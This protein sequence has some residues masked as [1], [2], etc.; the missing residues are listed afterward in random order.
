[1]SSLPI[2]GSLDQDWVGGG[3]PPA[4]ATLQAWEF[5]AE[6]VEPVAPGITDFELSADARVLAL[7]IGNRLR[8]VG[9]GA[10]AAE[11]ESK[12]LSGRAAG[13]IDMSRASVEMHPGAEWKQM[14]REAWRLQR[15]Q[16]WNEEMSGVD[17]KGVLERYLPLVERVG[18]RT[19]FS[20]LA[21]EMQGE[22][23]TSHCYEMGG[24]YQPFPMYGYDQGFLGAN[25][26][27][28]PRSKSWHVAGIL[29]GDSWIEGGGSP[30]A[31]PGLSVKKGDRIV[32]VD[33]QP[34][35][36]N[37][38]PYACLV[39]RAGQAVRLTLSSGKGKPRTIVIDASGEEHTLRYRDWVEANRARVHKATKGRVGYV[40]VPDMGPRGFAEFH[41]YFRAEV[42]RDGLI[43]DVRFN[44]GGHVSQLLLE[45]LLRKRIGYDEA[46]WQRGPF[47][48]P[49]MAPMG[50][51]VA[52]TN[53]YAGSDGDIFSQA[54]KIYG[55]GPL[56]GKRTWGGVVGIWPRHALV[57]GTVT[58]QPEFSF[59]FEGVGW[60]VEN[61]GVDPDIEVEITPQ[62]YAAGKDTQLERGLAEVQAIIKK[63][64]PGMPKF[65][66]RPNLKPPRLS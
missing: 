24:D 51:M 45:K 39:N 16:F 25:L 59:W 40:H 9:S 63:T 3:E 21:W 33:G 42:D 49:D 26:E 38:S 5:D 4:H 57:D 6:K 22:L 11:L 23:G 52:L 17:W 47:T 8:V 50:P 64:K 58:S 12:E 13:W 14:L 30:L 15:D 18:T 43:V 35:G 32:A 54:W 56:I 44:G 2:E 37:R 60:G 66:K 29:E 7:R 20:D 65:E 28:R 62:D 61:Y 36:A 53:E 48:Y 55:L 41:R 34:V 19:E 46:R 31:A 27:Y 10:K 1:M